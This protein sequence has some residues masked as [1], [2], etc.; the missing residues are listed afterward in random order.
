MR[1]TNKD[2]RT[3]S[4]SKVG[5]KSR[6][7]NTVEHVIVFTSPGNDVLG[8]RQVETILETMCC[9]IN[10]VRRNPFSNIPIL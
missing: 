1:K 9:P 10:K 2:I 4:A 7:K 5:S 3:L 8:L 6:N